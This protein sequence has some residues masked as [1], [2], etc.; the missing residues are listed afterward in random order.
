MNPKNS[1]ETLL[2][3]FKIQIMAKSLDIDL[4]VI[5]KS[6]KPFPLNILADNNRI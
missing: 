2:D 1:V 5:E 4:K 3:Y 6:S